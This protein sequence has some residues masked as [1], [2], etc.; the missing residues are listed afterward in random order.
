MRRSIESYIHGRSAQIQFGESHHQWTIAALFYFNCR[1]GFQ[2][3]R[4]LAICWTGGFFNTFSLSFDAK[5]AQTAH[6]FDIPHLSLCIWNVV[7]TY[8]QQQ[9]RIKKHT[10]TF[11]YEFQWY[12]KT[13]EACWWSYSKLSCF[14]HVLRFNVASSAIN[15]S[16]VLYIL[17]CVWIVRLCF[18][19]VKFLRTFF[20][21]SNDL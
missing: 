9:Q 20:S 1:Y 5:C 6:M 15:E 18:V 4:L 8:E 13:L 7:Y 11:H 3:G 12:Q 19:H 10:T 16:I 2:F 17:H 21:L 14:I